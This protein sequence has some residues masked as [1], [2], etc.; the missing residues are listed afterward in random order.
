[1]KKL[2]L[3]LAALLLPAAWQ[4]QAAPSA[5]LLVGDGETVEDIYAPDLDS[6]LISYADQMTVNAIQYG[7]GGGLDALIDG[8]AGTWFHSSY[9]PTS[10][11]TDEEG[12]QQTI[13]NLYPAEKHW[14]QF[15]L[16]DPQTAIFFTWVIRSSAYNDTPDD[17]TFLVTN[18]PEEAKSWTE[19]IRLKDLFTNYSSTSQMSGQEYTSPM[20][21]FDAPYRYIRMVV[22][23][24]FSQRTEGTYGQYF[25]NMAEMQLY[26]ARLVDDPQERL[27]I[28]L[29][30]FYDLGM[31]MYGIQDEFKGNTPGFYGAEEVDAFMEVFERAI[32][33]ADAMPAQAPTNEEVDEMIIQLRA[34]YDALL[35]SQVKVGTGY[36]RIINSN[37]AYYINQGV[38]KA[39]VAST[40]GKWLR[41]GTYS[42]DDLSAIWKFTLLDDDNFSIQNMA[43]LTYIDFIDATSQ[44]VPMTE[45]Q[46]TGQI[47]SPSKMG[48][49]TI[50]NTQYNVPYHTESHNLGAGVEGYIVPWGNADEPN[51][52]WYIYEV[53]EEELARVQE[54]NDDVRIQADYQKAVAEAEVAML[55]TIE[56]ATDSE[57]PYIINV[58]DDANLPEESQLWTNA[59]ETQE[60][61]LEALIDGNINSYFHSVYS[62]DVLDIHCLYADLGKPVDKFV[63]TFMPRQSAYLD[64]PADIVIYGTNDISNW[65]DESAWTEVKHLA[66]GFPENA[67]T[68]YTSPG[69]LMDKPYRY[70]RFQ[71]LNTFS[72]RSV[73]NSLGKVLHFFTLSEFQVYPCEF[74]EA[75]SQYYNVEGM[76]D[77]V[78]ALRKIVNDLAAKPKVTRPDVTALE[79]AVQA[80]KDL[81]VDH[82]KLADELA[83]LIEEAERVVFKTTTP[84]KGLLTNASQFSANSV[85]QEGNFGNLLDENIDTYFHTN[86][87]YGAI[88]PGT[89]EDDPDEVRYGATHN[90]QVDMLEPQN[91][92]RIRFTPRNSGYRDWP[93]DIIIYA[94]NDVNLGADPLSEDSEWEQVAAFNDGFPASIT[95]WTSDEFD[96]GGNRYLRMV[97]NDTYSHK[98]EG[99]RLDP[100]GKPFFTLSEFQVMISV[101]M[102]EIQYSYVPD[103][104][105]WTDRLSALVAENKDK[106]KYEVWQRDIDAFE[107]AFAKLDSS[108]VHNDALMAA[109]SQ[110]RDMVEHAAVGTDFGYVPS[111]DVIN[112]LE[113]AANAAYDVAHGRTLQP[114]MDAEVTKVENAMKAFVSKVKMPEMNHW[115]NIVNSAK[116]SENIS[117]DDDGNEVVT[118]IHGYCSG[119]AIA[120]KDYAI[121]DPISFGYYD[122]EN[123]DATYG[124]AANAFWRFVPIEGTDFVGIQNMATGHYIGATT[125]QGDGD[126]RPVQTDEPAPYLIKYYGAGEILFYSQ[127]SLNV[128]GSNVPLHAQ[129]RNGA[130]LVGW[131]VEHGNASCWTLKEVLDTQVLTLPAQMNTVSIMSLPFDIPE[132]RSLSKLSAGDAHTYALS[133]VVANDDGTTSLELVEKEAIAAGEA[134]ILTFG[135]F[136]DETAE[137]TTENLFVPRPTDVDPLASVDANGLVSAIGGIDL[138]EEGLGY[139][140]NNKVAATTERVTTIPGLS[141]YIRASLCQSTGETPDL[142][143]TC[144]TPLIDAI[145]AIN[146]E[147]DKTF[148]GS[149]NVYDLGGR[150]VITPVKKGLYITRGRKVLVK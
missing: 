86:Y 41:W 9:G 143:L 37:D 54:I 144:G 19:A 121:G 49:F 105:K 100:R 134:F 38:E 95:E 68:S 63:F 91:T 149:E 84:V 34:T 15:E 89:S 45:E 33:A 94:T 117:Y 61:S 36:Y 150:R 5:K 116:T 141:G 35:A 10:T 25:W 75:H 120:T 43:S 130:P 32:V 96:A 118:I 77:A 115:Y 133:A 129:E 60:G 131:P 1:M 88:V 90:L 23:R 74:D 16:D 65:E 3:I 69:I 76:K 92:V 67:S 29:V 98:N 66:S 85:I 56:Y 97:V 127:D 135:D 78:D 14:I 82:G 73:T 28:A 44:H 11:I 79:E 137:H 103:V 46:T 30:P 111:Q 48:Q 107:E 12:N 72:Q 114:Q 124:D 83:V 55:T 52:V 70:L 31:Q 136:E 71:V 20:I 17:V 22:N 147:A 148:A 125:I 26:P 13:N 109:V 7:D 104:K 57:N 64:I 139:I 42:P 87:S 27:N 51:S 142:V 126:G 102:D 18:T 128:N 24:T 113:A 101:G 47:I 122:L 39:M 58:S 119:K 106:D 62:Y 59:F 108:F 112:T 99:N 2:I 110:A 21:T 146:V 8:D 6:P 132:E 145:R 93:V 140:R 53:T 4:V 40:D 81:Y 80:V 123:D 138:E 50:Y